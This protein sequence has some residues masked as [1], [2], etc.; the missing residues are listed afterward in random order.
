MDLSERDMMIK[1][2]IKNLKYVAMV[3]EAGAGP[4]CGDLVVASV[5]LN[6]SKEIKGL[7][8]SK[9]LTEKK[10]ELLYNEI[11]DKA[12][13]YKIIHIS[14]EEIDCLN[15]LQAR[16][17]GFKI[18]IEDLNRVDYALIDGNKLPKNLSI[19]ADYVIKG[20]SKFKGISAASILAKVSRD[21]QI[22]E[23][24]KKYPEYGFEKNKGYGTKF[25]MDALKKYGPCPIH[26]MS[27]KP[28]KDSIK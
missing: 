19:P 14:P 1:E 28:V 3:D 22:I 6:P 16:L 8:D 9:K 24:A 17:K 5:I 23:L 11:I 7:D 12:L 18:S 26:R 21:R 10:R 20:D 25:H 13:D 15:I 2:K 27:Y 4:L